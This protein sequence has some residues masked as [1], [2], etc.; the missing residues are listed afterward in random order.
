MPRTANWGARAFLNRLQLSRQTDRQTDRDRKLGI[1]HI[2]YITVRQGHRA[3]D[4]F[5]HQHCKTTVNMVGKDVE[6]IVLITTT[7]LILGLFSSER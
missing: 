1:K 4:E 5:G 3:W 6:M 2:D 7:Y